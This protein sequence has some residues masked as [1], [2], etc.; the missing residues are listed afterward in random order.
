[1]FG[2]QGVTE[3]EEAKCFNDLTVLEFQS[4]DRLNCYQIPLNAD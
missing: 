4:V 2:G 1:M 3:A